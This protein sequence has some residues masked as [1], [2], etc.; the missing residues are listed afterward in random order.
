MQ[1]D[2]GIELLIHVG[3]DTVNLK[4]KFF[5][6]CVENGTIV[7]KGD[8]LLNFDRKEIEKEGYD[9]S[10]PVIITNTENY[11]DI[12]LLNQSEDCEFLQDFLSVQ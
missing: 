10:T 4:G 1:S 2:E 8:V 6:P 12:I 7:K 9:L 3:I 5:H 11:T